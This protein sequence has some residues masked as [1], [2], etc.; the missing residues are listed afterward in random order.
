MEHWE[1]TETEESTC[2][3]AALTNEYFKKE[4]KNQLKFPISGDTITM[5]KAEQK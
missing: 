1:I 4:W 2:T 3:W 5:W